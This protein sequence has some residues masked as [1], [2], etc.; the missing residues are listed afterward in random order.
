MQKRVLFPDV[1]DSGWTGVKKGG[2]VVFVCVSLWSRCMGVGVSM[3][4]C[5]HSRIMYEYQTL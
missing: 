5:R 3:G 1:Y 2:W 4:G